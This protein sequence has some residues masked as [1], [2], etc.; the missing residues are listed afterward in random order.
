LAEQIAG[1]MGPDVLTL[2]IDSP[3]G[4]SSGEASGAN[5]CLTGGMAVAGAEPRVRF[6]APTGKGPYVPEQN[7]PVIHH[8]SGDQVIALV[9]IV[10]PGNK[11]NRH[12]IRTFVEKAASALYRGYHLLILDL[13][14]PGPRDPN[15]IHGS[16]WEEIA[17]ASF[18]LPADKPLTLV[19]YS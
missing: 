18:R 7:T 16:I 9:E 14:P 8:S 10:S 4:V 11:S 5:G 6:T 19:G 12:G 17:D 1:N 2:E 15:G 13:Q 3:N